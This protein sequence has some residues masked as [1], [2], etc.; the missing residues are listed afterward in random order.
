M[1]GGTR[2][3]GTFFIRGPPPGPRRTAP[4]CQNTAAG[5]IFSSQVLLLLNTLWTCF[6]GSQ[7]ALGLT[8]KSLLWLTRL[9]LPELFSPYQPSPSL[10]SSNQLL[11]TVRRANPKIGQRT[12]SRSSPVIWNA[13]PLS[14]R[15]ALSISSFKRRLKLIILLS[16]LCLLTSAT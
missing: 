4:G 9:Y 14:V 8:S 5:L 12:F 11:L 2:G 7:S 13:I 15:E 3:G 6:T 16:L 10:R 1:G